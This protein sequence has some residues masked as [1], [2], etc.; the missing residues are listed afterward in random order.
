MFVGTSHGESEVVGASAEVAVH[1]VTGDGGGASYLCT[2]FRSLFGGNT[3]LD[4]ALC[5]L[6]TDALCQETLYFGHVLCEHSAYKRL[7]GPETFGKFAFAASA[8]ECKVCE[9]APTPTP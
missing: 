3:S 6:C 5:H 2:L 7:K 4:V 9:H 1:A 8:G